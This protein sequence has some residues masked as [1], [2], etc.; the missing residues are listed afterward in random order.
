[1]FE[2]QNGSLSMKQAFLLIDEH[3]KSVDDEV[4]QFAYNSL[5]EIGG[6]PEGYAETIELLSQD[7][8]LRDVIDYMNS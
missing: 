7:P 2:F 8:T 4:V 6:F 3:S 1:M 5:S